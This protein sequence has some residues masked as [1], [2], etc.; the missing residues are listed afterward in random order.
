MLNP[1]NMILRQPI[2]KQVLSVLR[3]LSSGIRFKS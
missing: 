2:R 3:V 1:L